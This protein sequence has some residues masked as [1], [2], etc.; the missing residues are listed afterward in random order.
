MTDERTLERLIAHLRGQVSELRRRASEG[1][2]PDEL[3]ER[4]LVVFRLQQQL[5][6]AVRDLLNLRGPSPI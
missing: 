2:A 3:A 6:F 4:R 1:A 5:A